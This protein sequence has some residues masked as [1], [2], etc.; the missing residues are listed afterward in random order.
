MSDVFENPVTQVS[1]PGRP[2]RQRHVV[3]ALM[4]FSL[5]LGIAVGAVIT[6]GALADPDNRITLSSQPVG[7]DSL[8]ASFARASELVEPCVVSID[9]REGAE[10]DFSRAGKGSGVIVT[11][12]GYILTNFHVVESATSI[13]V[14]LADRRQFEGKVVGRDRETDLAV[15]KIE[16]RDPL[17]SAR[18]GDSD[19]LRVG[20]WVLAIGSP[21]GLEQTVTAG[22]ISARERETDGPG[23]SAFQKFL[24]TDAAI[25][26]GNSGG[27]LVNLG[28]EV[29]GINTQIATRTG[30]FSGIGLALPSRTAVEV[31]NQ[32][33]TS[34]RVGRGFL[35]IRIGEITGDIARKNGLEGT[36]G[37]LVSDLSSA[38]SPAGRAGIT[39]GDII[40]ELNGEPVKDG[41]ELIRRV[42]AM[43]VGSVVRLTY[44]RE[45]Q[46]GSATVKLTDRESGVETSRSSDPPT[47]PPRP[48]YDFDDE[49]PDALTPDPVEP[50]GV[51]LALR[52]LTPDLARDRNLEG[53]TGALVLDVEGGSPAARAGLA[54]GD[55][56]VSA[57]GQRIAGERD[58][59]GLIAGAASGD[60][61]VVGVARRSGTKIERR[62]VTIVVP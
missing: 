61:I 11:A 33:I 20:D 17:P 25:N 40:T 2:A 44:V 32:L 60:K 55:V 19:R 14:R 48:M 41:R 58:F 1:A 18:F 37:V 23:S 3:L 49:D 8:S 52:T 30:V 59:D 38:D 45:G 6:R 16:A 22:I 54:M 39:S 10:G 26:P 46:P 15:V 53:I 13:T 9:T 62:F 43:P 50:Q 5:V 56:V 7:A 12:T 27:P 21:F 51:G 28:G 57:D 29:I 4:L 42:G 31:Y 34:G 24:Q 36:D 47:G 35:G